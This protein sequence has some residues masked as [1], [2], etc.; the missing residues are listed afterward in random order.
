M[1]HPEDDRLVPACVQHAVL[2]PRENANLVKRL[3]L[4]QP[5]E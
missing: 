5:P 4:H 3:P 2:D 1:A